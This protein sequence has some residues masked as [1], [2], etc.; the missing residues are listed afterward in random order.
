MVN[1][2]IEYL[3]YEQN[4]S[5]L[6]VARYERS[7][8][9]F[10]SYFKGI[11]ASMAWTTIDADVVRN[12]LETLV[13]KG[14]KA[15]SVNADLSALR[16]FYRF[17]LSRKLV[18]RDPVHGLTGPKKQKPLPQFMRENDMDKLLDQEEWSDTYKDVRARTI[19]LLLYET[20]I[21]RSELTGLNDHDIDFEARQLKVTGKRD[22][23]RIVPFGEE[24]ATELQRYIEVRDQEMEKKSTALFLNKHGERMTGCQ[25]YSIVREELS[26]VTTMKKRSPHVL[27]HTF[28][29]AMLN[30]EAGLESVRLLL[31][32]ESLETTEIYTHTTF[33]QLKRVYKDAHPRG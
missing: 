3:R 32:H 28:A 26:K 30:H 20:G 16:S 25:V 33:E 14:H 10:E 29:T 4:R 23:Q 8:R 11:D 21:R 18:E 12:W 22:K 31:G 13:D 1:R 7:L 27:R 6:T 9:D 17:A 5:E 2:F 15:T 24:L 19:I